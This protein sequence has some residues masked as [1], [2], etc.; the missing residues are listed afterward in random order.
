LMFVLEPAGVG[1]LL[2]GPVGEMAATVLTAVFGI[3]ALAAGVQNWL[4]QALVPLER[5]GLLISGWLLLYPGALN[6][7]VGA[8]LLA[9]TAVWHWARTR[10]ASSAR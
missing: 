9:V 8:T 3:A 6:D 1:L 10:P 4:R 5:A 2:K 7:G